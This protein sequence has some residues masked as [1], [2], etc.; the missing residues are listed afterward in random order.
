MGSLH[1]HTC[2]ISTVLHPQ[3][4]AQGF[5]HTCIMSAAMHP[6]AC[7]TNLYTAPQDCALQPVSAALHPQACCTNLYT[8]PQDYA[9]QPVLPGS[10]AGLPVPDLLGGQVLH[11]WMDEQNIVGR[12]EG[13]DE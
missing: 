4:L 10:F 7:F 8:A 11:A 2:I 9:L 13:R 12:K 5:V 1:A 6:Q 3:I